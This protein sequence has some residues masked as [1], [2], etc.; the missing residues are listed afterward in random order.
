VYC[1]KKRN[2]GDRNNEENGSGM[3]LILPIEIQKAKD[4]TSAKIE[5][6][7]DFYIFVR[8]DSTYD[9]YKQPDRKKQCYPKRQQTNHAAKVSSE[10]LESI[11]DIDYIPM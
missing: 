3:L 10:T 4:N 8:Y 7:I 9:C 1:C 5:I 6:N 11:Y 2:R